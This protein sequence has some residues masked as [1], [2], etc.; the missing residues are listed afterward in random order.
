MVPLIRSRQLVTVAPV[1]PAK[2]EVGDIVLARVAGRSTCVWSRRSIGRG[3]EFRS[4]ATEG[5][6]TVGPGKS[7]FTESALPSMASGVLALRARSA[8]NMTSE[9]RG[10][11]A[12]W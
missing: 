3:R 6:S 5:A 8:G 2:V 11:E 12:R 9:L 1:D 4:A 7:A 10:Y